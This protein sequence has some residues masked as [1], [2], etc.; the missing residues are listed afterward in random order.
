MCSTRWKREQMKQCPVFSQMRQR[1][2]KVHCLTNPVT[3]Q[4]VANVLLAAG[5]S[6][7]MAQDAA[8]V[9][10]ITALC[11]A[12]LLNTGVPSPEKFRAC[13][14]AGVRANGLGHP[15]V[16]DP[17]GAGASAFRRSQLG[18]LLEQVRP[19]IIRCNQEEAAALLELRQE[20][21]LHL[22][23]GGVESGLAAS[24]EAACALAAQLAQAAGCTVL[25]TGETDVVTDGTTLDTLHGGDAR[26]RRITGGGCMLSALCALFCG[27]GVAAFD[28]ARLAGQFWRDCAAQ[29]GK[30]VGQGQIGTFH[31]ALFDAVSAAVW[32]EGAVEA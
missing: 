19:T 6:A 30:R 20:S 26:I 9:E 2:P 25:M 10:E 8:E 18:A 21:G 22:T 29:A 17:V 7:V 11:D 27:G 13:T 14:L 23:S 16:L 12:T 15:V 32:K 5:G 24:E 28:A 4:D 3:M 1:A 31:M